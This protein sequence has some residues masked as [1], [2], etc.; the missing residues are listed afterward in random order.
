MCIGSHT[1]SGTLYRLTSAAAAAAD[2]RSAFTFWLLPVPLPYLL[3]SDTP[4]TSSSA[5]AAAA[6]TDDDDGCDGGCGA[7]RDFR[8]FF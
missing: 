3:K 5:D 1:F 4:S 7:A 2:V 6:A 8:L